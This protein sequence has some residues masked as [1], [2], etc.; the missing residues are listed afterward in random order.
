MCS[1]IS[2]EKL[3]FTSTAPPPLSGK[4]CL[5]QVLFRP[6]E[7][8]HSCDL[9]DTYLHVENT[10]KFLLHWSVSSSCLKTH[11]EFTMYEGSHQGV[12]YGWGS[13]FSPPLLCYLFAKRIRDS[14]QRTSWVLFPPRVNGS[15]RLVLH[16]LICNLFFTQEVFICFLITKSLYLSITQVLP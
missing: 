4:L 15:F 2:Q 1:E 7:L 14:L 10:A 16:L 3:S 6:S 12:I 5:T 9:I 11:N 8:K 13:W